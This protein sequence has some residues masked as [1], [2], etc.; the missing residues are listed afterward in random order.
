MKW[1]PGNSMTCHV[2]Q[3]INSLHLMEKKSWLHNLFISKF[4]TFRA[5]NMFA[6]K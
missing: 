4:G 2:L 1:D 6:L 3:D 5:R